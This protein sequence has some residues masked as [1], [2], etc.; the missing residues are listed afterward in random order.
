MSFKISSIATVIATTSLLTAVN[1][2]AMEFDKPIITPMPT[3]TVTG[4]VGEIKAVIQ[5]LKLT[6]QEKQT[7]LNR[8]INLKK[9]LSDPALPSSVDLGMNSVPVF[10]QGMQSTC[11]TFAVSAAI[12]A[13]LGKGDYISQ[14]CNLELGNYLAQNGYIPSGWNGT[15]GSVVLSQMMHFG[16][17]N[18]EQQQKGCAG[19]TNYPILYGSGNPMSLAEFKSK[20]EDLTKLITWEHIFG[21]DQT[22]DPPTPPAQVMDDVLLKIK[23]ELAKGHRV[24]FGT[25]LPVPKNCASGICG[26]Y[27]LGLDTWVITKDLDNPIEIGG[28]QMVIYGYDDNAVAKDSYGNS[29]VG[30]LKLRNSWSNLLGNH[31]EFY[32]S[33]DYFKKYAIDAQVIIKR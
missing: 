26:R 31:G 4:G 15:F 3:T 20:S 32:M 5:G 18:K 21:S 25:Y 30:L 29:H 14:L 24:T 7:I 33:Y 19:V 23:H 1:V 16:I 13:A 27:Q 17:V 10:F 8:K 2:Y 22:F 12:D 9:Q 6:P 28:H 11:V